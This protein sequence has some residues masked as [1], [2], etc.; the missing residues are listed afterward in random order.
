MPPSPTIELGDVFE[1]NKGELAIVTSYLNKRKVEVEFIGE[2][3]CRKSFEAVDLRRGSFKNPMRP[4]LYGVGYFGFCENERSKEFSKIYGIWRMMLKR[5]YDESQQK[6]QHT[7][8][9]CSVHSDWHCFQ[10]FY[11]WYVSQVGFNS[12]Y[13]LD[14]DLLVRGIRVYSAENCCLLPTEKN[15]SIQSIDDKDSGVHLRKG[16]EVYQANIGG[17]NGV[18]HLG[19]FKNKTD[20]RNCYQKSLAL[21]MKGFAKE[22]KGRVE[23]K[24]YFRLHELAKEIEVAIEKG[25]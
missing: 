10:S 6:I 7:Y 16:S 23:E 1:S 5:C 20:A 2:N 3:I 9:G 11:G 12:S 21:K 19:T 8:I 22:Y 17:K 4:M 14:K 15:M 13:Q 18:K 25:L 24:V